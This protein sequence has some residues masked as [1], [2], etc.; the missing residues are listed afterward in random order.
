MNNTLV[1][2]HYQVL[3][4]SLMKGYLVYEHFRPILIIAHYWRVLFMIIHY[5]NIDLGIVMINSP[6]NWSVAGI[7][8][9]ITTKKELKALKHTAFIVY[10]VMLV[11]LHLPCCHYM[12]LTKYSE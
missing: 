8:Y 2:T 9:T 5:Y 6:L 7:Y 10:I 11:C 4:C 1:I 3:L 12:K